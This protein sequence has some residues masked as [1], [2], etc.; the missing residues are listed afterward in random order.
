MLLRDKGDLTAAEPLLREALK[1]LQETLGSRHPR[2]RNLVVALEGAGGHAAD[3]STSAGRPRRRRAATLAAAQHLSTD[4][5][6]LSK[7]GPHLRRARRRPPPPRGA[8]RAPPRAAG[9]AAG[10][11]LAPHDNPLAPAARLG[12]PPTARTAL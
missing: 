12:A 11:A 8:P 2:T 4:R 6:N 1:V 5:D 10:S 3:P 9:P 7:R